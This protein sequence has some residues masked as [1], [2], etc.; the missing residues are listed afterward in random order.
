MFSRCDLFP[1]YR[2]ATKNLDQT[3]AR[4]TVLVVRADFLIARSDLGALRPIFTAAT[5]R[6]D[7]RA[8]GLFCVRGPPMMV[9]VLCTCV[10]HGPL[11]APILY[12][13]GIGMGVINPIHVLLIHLEHGLLSNFGLWI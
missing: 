4:Y 7:W 13:W 8:R 5:V 9:W 6:V 2:K 3:S 10:L 1:F 11:C 12:F